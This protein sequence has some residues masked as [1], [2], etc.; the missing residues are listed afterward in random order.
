MSKKLPKREAIDL[1]TWFPIANTITHRCCRCGAK[2]VFKFKADFKMKV[3][4]K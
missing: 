2:H 4:D 3:S 1:D